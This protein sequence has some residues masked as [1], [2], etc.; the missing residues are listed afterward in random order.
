M[1]LVH[2]D[3]IPLPET[4]D[5]NFINTVNQLRPIINSIL[6]SGERKTSVKELE[7]SLKNSAENAVAIHRFAGLLLN[8]AEI[9]DIAC[10]S[11]YDVFELVRGALLPPETLDK[12]K[13]I[14][15]T[16]IESDEPPTIRIGLPERYK[17]N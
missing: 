5:E 15:E 10:K 1:E 3:N 4:Y 16:T 11:G 2:P 7:R 14:V 13:I 12:P 9:L 17:K 6:E 8:N